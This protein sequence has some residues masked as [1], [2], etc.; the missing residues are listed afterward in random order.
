LL[1][2]PYEIYNILTNQSLVIYYDVSLRDFL[3][4]YPLSAEILLSIYEEEKGSNDKDMFLPK[5]LTLED[6]ENIISKYLDSEVANFN[7][8]KL[9]FNTRDKKDFNISDKTRL[10]AKQQYEAKIKEIF[11]DR[12]NNLL[13]HG[14]HISFLEKSG[15]NKQV[16]VEDGVY[17]FS[18]NL[19]YIK[20]NNDTLSLF[21]NFRKLFEYLDEQARINLVSKEKDLGIMER[22]LGVHSKNEYRIGVSFNFLE[23]LSNAQMFNYDKVI[24][25]LGNTLENILRTIFI[26]TFQEKYNFASNAR[27][28]MP[29][30]N[31]SYFEKIRLLAPEF[32]SILKQYKLFVENGGIDFDLLQITS[33]PSSIKEIPSLVSNKYIYLNEQNK[34]IIGCSNLFF[35]DQTILGYVEPFKEKKYSTLFD[36]L[37]NEQVNYDNYKVFQKEKVNYLIDKDFL[38]LNENQFIQITNNERVLILKDLYE[39]E[40]ASFHHYA[41]LCQGEA[42]EMKKQNMIVF[43]TSLF[44]KP[45]QDYFNFF[46]NKKEFTNGP[47]LRNSYLHGTQANPEDTQKHEYAYFI[48]LKLLTLVLLKMEDDLFISQ[49]NG[50]NRITNE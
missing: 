47:D 43:E 7:Y 2:E 26:S 17:Y 27:I 8:L 28:S 12:N 42:V 38:F 6:K 33:K 9:I 22:A 32:E 41:P 18:Y 13:K 24:N 31:V 14:I 5:K 4:N 39:N 19:T 35:S 20:Q 45:E 50:K 29:S 34:E 1:N 37:I 25:S 11:N 36:L 44:S 10:K 46:L 3:L 48:Y 21:H 30:A 16:T 15:K 40:V 23:M 49:L